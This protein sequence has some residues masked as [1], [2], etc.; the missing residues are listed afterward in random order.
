MHNRNELDEKIKKFD[1]AVTGMLFTVF[2]SF[3]TSLIVTA[4]L[5]KLLS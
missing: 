5:I 1:K 4:L 2:S 3:V